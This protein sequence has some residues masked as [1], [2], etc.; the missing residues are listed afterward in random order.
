MAGDVFS[1]PMVR[2]GIVAGVD[3]NNIDLS[4]LDLSALDRVAL[5]YG[6][7]PSSVQTALTLV[8]GAVVAYAAFKIVAKIVKGIITS[9]IVAILAFLLTTVPGNMILSHAYDR[10][11]QQVT[12][13]LSQSH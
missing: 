6:G 1:I 13:S 5:W 8:V 7:L 11:E 3:L 4:N 9:V 10:V 12:A 2:G